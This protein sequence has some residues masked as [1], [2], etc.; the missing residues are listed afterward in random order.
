MKGEFKLI[1]RLKRVV[2]SPKQGIGIGDDTAVLPSTAGK[3][4][5][6]TTDMLAEGSHFFKGTP[7]RW[8]GHKA[9]ACSLSDIA[10]MGGIPKAAVVS[11]GIPE[12]S[13]V[14]R[15]EAVYQG[16]RQLAEQFHVDIVGGDTIKSR[17]LVVNVALTGEIQGSRVI[18]RKG[19][20]PGDLIYVTGC[21]GRSLSTR[22]H[23]EF[24]PRL[25]ESRFL[26]EK[27]KPTAMIDVSDGLAADLGHVLSASR[28]SAVLDEKLIP[29]RKK[30]SLKEALYDGEDF[31]L[32]FT[33][34]PKKERLLTGQRRFTFTRIGQ[35]EKG[36]PRIITISGSGV[37]SVRQMKGFEHF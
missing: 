24:I 4:L 18:T 9:L 25:K 11:L 36:R 37:K 7:G 32:L 21:F 30:A 29:R 14:A 22:H 16:M 2:G 3:C 1:R 15:I 19:A 13:S 35:I 23:L 6:L 17:Q 33:V 34:S 26:A 5:L 27:V 20:C 28:V 8:I 12:R 10:A 31:E